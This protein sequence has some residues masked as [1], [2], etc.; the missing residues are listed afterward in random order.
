MIKKI[1]YIINVDWYFKLHWLE[2]A[3]YFKSLGYEIYIVS[4]FTDDVIKDYLCK[5]GFIC[6][7]ITLSR[8]SINIFREIK[9]IVDIG[10]LLKKIQPDLV[11]SITVKPNLYVGILNSLFFKKRIVYSVTGLGAIFSSRTIKYRIL[12]C[13]V[14]VLYKFISKSYSRFIFENGDD[15]RLF[16][17]IGILKNNN[18]RVI[19]GAGIDLKHFTSEPS[20]N[21]INILF[22]ARLLKDKGLEYLIF[23]KRKLLRKGVHFNLNVAGIIDED[24][25]SAIPIKQINSWV[26]TGDIVWLGNV[27]DMPKLISENDIVCLPT[28]YGEGVPRILIEA[29]SCQRAIVTTD[30]PGCREI[31]THGYNGLL[32]APKDVDSLADCLFDLLSNPQKTREFGIRG[33]QIVES[34][35]AQQIVFKDTDEVYRE[36]FYIR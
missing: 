32:A 15:Y 13:L 2:R 26:N 6:F 7:D 29:A 21:N 3:N 18:G 5:K 27:Q 23:A 20:K 30:V 34:E 4:H 9:T 33:R 14:S 10:S 8:S 19:K 17:D 28:I 12:R 36:L 35:Y 22:A 25:S 24:S 1:V 11:H 31:V 16:N